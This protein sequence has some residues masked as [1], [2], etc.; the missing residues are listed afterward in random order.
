MLLKFLFHSTSTGWILYAREKT[1][2]VPVLLILLDTQDNIFIAKSL[3]KS[4]FNGMES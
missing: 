1:S 3:K 2:E 4:P